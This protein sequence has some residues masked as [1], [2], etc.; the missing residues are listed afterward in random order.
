MPKS[1]EPFD[2]SSAEEDA[3]GNEAADQAMRTS[4]T[5]DLWLDT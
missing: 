4:G 2:D 3:S 1:G 5:G